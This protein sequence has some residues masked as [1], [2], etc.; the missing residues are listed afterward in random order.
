MDNS[1]WK[2]KF[3]KIFEYSSEWYIQFWRQLYEEYK[4]NP[5]GYLLTANEK[6]KVNLNN[7]GYEAVSF[8]EDEF[9]SNFDIEEDKNKWIWSS[10]TEIAN[11]LNERC[12]HL[13]IDASKMGKLIN[14]IE[15]KRGITFDRKDSFEKQKSLKEELLPYKINIE[16]QDEDLS[17]DNVIFWWIGRGG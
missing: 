10:A 6:E 1:Y 14:K 12:K 9:I 5:K 15:D 2:N 7:N 11:L 3:K 17:K 16:S 13:R 4:Q 8:G